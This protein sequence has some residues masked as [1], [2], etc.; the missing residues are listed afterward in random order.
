MNTLHKQQGMTLI[1]LM[2]AGVLSLTIAY[3]IM[4]IMVTSSR[5]A[6]QS[7]GLAQAQENGRFTLSW[8]ETNIRKAGYLPGTSQERIQPFADLCAD[9]L[10]RPPASG[11][12][13]TFESNTESDRIAVRRTFVTSSTLASDY[14]DCTGVDLRGTVNDGDVLVDVYWTE[15]NYDPGSGVATDDDYNDVLRCVTYYNNNPVSPA[16]VIASGI[17]S[18]QVLYGSRPS[19]DP[20]NR[21]NVNRYTSLADIAPVDWDSVRS[22]RIAVLTRSFSNTTTAQDTRSY[23]VLDADP[24]TFTDRIARHIQSTTI[25]L[26]NE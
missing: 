24:L 18:L 5:T 26:P 15:L 4:N 12:D 13:C 22:V 6:V 7:E 1:E 19:A 23:I 3:F 2:I 21:N 10:P 9:V 25:Y 17:E 20:Q 16:Q 8:L 14:S 11:A